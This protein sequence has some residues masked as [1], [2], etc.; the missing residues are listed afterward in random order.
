MT[1]I[2]VLIKA[3]TIIIIKKLIIAFEFEES[4]E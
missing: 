4:R 1:I 3:I 2:T